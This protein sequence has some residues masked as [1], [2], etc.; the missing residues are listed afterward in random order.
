MS[1]S[2]R[3]RQ[4]RAAN[5]RTVANRSNAN[6]HTEAAI[7]FKKRPPAHRA[8]TVLQEIRASKQPQNAVHHIAMSTEKTSRCYVLLEANY[9]QALEYRPNVAVLPWGACEAHNYHLPHGSDVIESSRIAERAAQLAFDRGSK[10]IVLPAI[11]YGNNAQQQD[12]VATIHCSTGT[13]AAILDDVAASLIRQDIDRLVILNG[14]GGNEFKPLV[15]DAQLKHHIFITLINFWQ[16]CPEVYD[17]IYDVPGDHADEMETSL[18]LHLCPEWVALDQAGQGTRKPF[19]IEGLSQ[20][21]VWTPRPWSQVHPDTGCG[22]PS[23]AT[24]EKG[25]QHFELV[26]EAIGDILLA[27]SK[28]TKGD[29]PYV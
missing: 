1:F 13:A 26:T 5:W 9:Q 25:A 17:E 7:T 15:R 10:P 3:V 18:L 19:A 21:G 29:L 24:A 8:V 28:A 11:P 27:I 14:H 20:S 16:V 23:A 12:Q 22:D 4:G 2:C 6:S